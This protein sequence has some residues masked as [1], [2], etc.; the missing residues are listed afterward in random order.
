MCVRGG[1]QGGRPRRRA[2]FSEE[3]GVTTIDYVQVHAMSVREA[4]QHV[5]P[6]LCRLSVAFMVRTF[7]EEN[8]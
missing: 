1:G 8:R 4:G 5:Q 3:T 2:I 7:R 6:D